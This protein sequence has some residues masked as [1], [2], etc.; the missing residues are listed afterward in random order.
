[1]GSF[2]CR[3]STPDPVPT[4]L[5]GVVGSIIGDGIAQYGASRAN[6]SPGSFSYDVPRVTR[7][8]AY[9]AL[10]GTPIGHYWFHFLDKVGY[11]RNLGSA[12]SVKWRSM[13]HS[14]HLQ[15]LTSC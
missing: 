2:V 13:A 8:C 6:R 12:A 3:K 1:M 5:A 7:L 4:T 11:K 9:S 10:I 14:P 15:Q